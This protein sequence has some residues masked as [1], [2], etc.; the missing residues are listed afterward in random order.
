MVK[1]PN[2]G[3]DWCCD[4]PP[5][6]DDSIWQECPISKPLEEYGFHQCYSNFTKRIIDGKIVY[7]KWVFQD[8][9][10]GIEKLTTTESFLIK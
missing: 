1:D 4:L 8:I 3:D 6:G 9:L 2:N 5:N 7:F 10:T